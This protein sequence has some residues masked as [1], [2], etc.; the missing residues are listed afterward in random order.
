LEVTTF[1]EE[2][3][4]TSNWQ[5]AYHPLQISYGNGT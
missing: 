2:G 3:D 1:E 4:A 5:A